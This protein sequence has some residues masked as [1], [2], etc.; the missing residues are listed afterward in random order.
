[1][2]KELNSGFEIGMDLY[3]KE[4]YPAAIKFFDAFISN[5][6]GENIT[7]ITD[8]EYYG[9]RSALKLL[10][11]DAEYRMTRFILTHPGSSRINDSY[12]A[13]RT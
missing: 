5:N 9:A 4:K 7:E 8:A 10:N 1:M 12:L 6:T 3:N 2:E 11:S 13:L